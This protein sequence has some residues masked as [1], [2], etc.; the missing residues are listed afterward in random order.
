VVM[1]A[2]HTGFNQSGIAKQNLSSYAL[3]VTLSDN[4]HYSISV[5][6]ARPIGDMPV[7]S[8]KRDWRYNATFTYN[9][10]AGS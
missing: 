10:S 2:A 6:A 9:F 8:Q 1:D 4:R 5:E 7:D 3:G